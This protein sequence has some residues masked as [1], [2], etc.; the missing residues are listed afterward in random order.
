MFHVCFFRQSIT[1]KRNEHVFSLT[2]DKKNWL[3]AIILPLPPFIYIFNQY[4]LIT[5]QRPSRN[6]HHHRQTILHSSSAL[7]IKSGLF[8][9]FRA[10]LMYT[11]TFIVCFRLLLLILFLHLKYS[12]EMSDLTLILYRFLRFDKHTKIVYS[13]FCY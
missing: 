13:C 1:P 7:D 11:R 3:K 9:M 12:G 10:L 8:P 5:L 4:F 6:L 2:W